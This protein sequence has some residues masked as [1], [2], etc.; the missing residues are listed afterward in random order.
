MSSLAVKR[1]SA[2][3][4]NIKRNKLEDHNIHVFVD[5]EDIFKMKALI[6]G[7]EDTPY[8][9]GFYFFFLEIPKDY[10]LNPPK[11]KFINLNGNVR[12]HPNLYKCGKVC[13]SILNTWHG[14]GWTS[15]QTLSSV[16]L[17]IQSVMNEHPIQNE[18]GWETEEGVKSK[19]F[20]NVV[21]YYNIETSIIKALSETIHGYE[22]FK[23]IMISHFI[24]NIK[25]YYKFLEQGKKLQ[26]KKIKS[27]IYGMVI[28]YYNYEELKEELDLLYSKYD[29]L[30]L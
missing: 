9:N 18:P 13:L 6:I 28:P 15:V 2:D 14:P 10:P 11:V 23:D 3:I 24:K 26:G 1:I 20:N 4:K 21:S 17:S 12:F 30:L 22:V 27:G 29:N 7:P 8:E 25:K 5:D 16:L 19:E